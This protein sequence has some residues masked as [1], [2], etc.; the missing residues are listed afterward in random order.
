[1]NLEKDDLRMLISSLPAGAQRIVGRACAID[2][3]RLWDPPEVVVQWLWTDRE[4]LREDAATWAVGAAMHYE[5]IHDNTKWGAANAAYGLA[6]L[7][8]G[9]VVRVAATEAAR[10]TLEK[11][12][13]PVLLELGDLD[14]TNGL[15]CYRDIWAAAAGRVSLIEILSWGNPPNALARLRQR[16]GANS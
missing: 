13:W 3:L 14:E 11:R 8:P 6:S 1:M 9:G 7:E 15:E 2:A 5:M 10:I 12:M 4:D 16:L